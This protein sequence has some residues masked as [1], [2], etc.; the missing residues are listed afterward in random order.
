[1]PGTMRGQAAAVYMIV[2]NIIGL[3][4]G[5]LAV[6]ML[7]QLIFKDQ[8]A[9]GM[10]VGLVVLASGV[11]CLTFLLLAGRAYAHLSRAAAGETD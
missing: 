6:A 3:G 4:G 11:T 10:S 8:M 9:A 2:G 5:P 7:T 1:V